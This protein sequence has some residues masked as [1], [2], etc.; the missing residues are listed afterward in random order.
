MFLSDVRTVR[1]ISE[2]KSINPGVVKLMLDAGMHIETVSH[3]SFISREIHSSTISRC[4]LVLPS[5]IRN[6]QIHTI[7]SYF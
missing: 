2:P 3:L 7:I 1:I 6:P 5:R 4:F